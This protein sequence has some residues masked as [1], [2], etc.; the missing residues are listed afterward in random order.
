MRRSV[1]RNNPHLGDQ[2]YLLAWGVPG[3]RT[4]RFKIREVPG[5]WD[6]M[7]TLLRASSAQRIISHGVNRR[8]KT[9]EFTTNKFEFDK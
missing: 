2:L 8:M 5:N 9:R 4:V 6:E 3:Y 1:V 7:V